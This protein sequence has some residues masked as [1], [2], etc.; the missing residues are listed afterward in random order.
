MAM[1]LED[2][3]LYMAVACPHGPEPEL[4]ALCRAAIRDGV[5]IVELRAADGATAACLQAAGTIAGVCAAED[6]LFV[7]DDPVVAEAAGA[8]GL[9][10]GDPEMSIGEARAVAGLEKLIGVP[11]ATAAEAQLAEEIG[12]DFLLLST[13]VSEFGVLARIRDLARVPVFP[14]GISNESDARRLLDMGFFRLCFEADALDEAAVA[15][16]AAL[17]S[18]MLGRV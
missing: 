6:A 10:I 11:A 15:Q 4:E 2:A 18:R 9:T 1:R 12:A 14:G 17:F 5:D 8:D 13:R 16:R 7:V 3:Q